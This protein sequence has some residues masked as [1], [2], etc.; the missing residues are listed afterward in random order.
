MRRP[1]DYRP[2]VGGSKWNELVA[3]LLRTE[4]EEK[5]HLLVMQESIT[6]LFG[7]ASNPRTMIHLHELNTELTRLIASKVRRIDVLYELLA[8]REK[9]SDED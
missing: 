9:V 4:H 3:M 8:M 6:A 1:S 2:L 5:D 7:K